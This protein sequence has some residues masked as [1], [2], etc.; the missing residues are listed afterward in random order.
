MSEQDNI[1]DREMLQHGSEILKRIPNRVMRSYLEGVPTLSERDV[2]VLVLRWSRPYKYASTH[3]QVG[4]IYGI[5]SVSAR[6]ID[7]K[8]LRRLVI[9]V[10]MKRIVGD[11]PLQVVFDRKVAAWVATSSDIGLS[12]KGKTLEVLL[13]KIRDAAPDII[14]AHA[15]PTPAYRTATPAPALRRDPRR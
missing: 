15:P 14:T 11:R 2:G 13:E 10:E 3:Q 9:G 5:T 1:T 12:I 4:E 6:Q 7:I 8:A